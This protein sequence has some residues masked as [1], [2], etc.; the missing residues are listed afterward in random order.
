MDLSIDN[1][2]EWTDLSF[3]SSQR[4]AEDRRGWREL[5]MRSSV[6]PY[7]P[8]KGYGIDDDD[9]SIYV[10]VM[11]SIFFEDRLMHYCSYITS[12]Y[13]VRYLLIH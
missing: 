4:A 13:V 10:H 5:V 3:G 1:I 11:L 7:D 9:L 8:E 2:K 6:V 12:K